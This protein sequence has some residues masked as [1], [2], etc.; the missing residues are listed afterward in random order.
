L[1]VKFLALLKRYEFFLK[2]FLQFIF[3]CGDNNA[4]KLVKK[5]GGLFKKTLQNFGKGNLKFSLIK[6]N[7]QQKFS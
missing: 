4:E 6:I 2:N 3:Y 1:Q 7:L 5:E